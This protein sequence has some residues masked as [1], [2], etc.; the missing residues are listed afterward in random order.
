MATAEP[1]HDPAN[2]PRLWCVCEYYLPNFSGA[3]IQAHRI[4]ARLVERGF[5]VSVLAMA[6]QASLELAGQ[7]TR[8]D[9]VDVRYLPVLRQRSWGE[10]G[11]SS[12]FQERLRA[13]NRSLR[14]LSFQLRQAWFF[15]RHARPGDILQLYVVDDWTWLAVRVAR[16]KRMR[17][18]I[19]ISLVGAD[20]PASFRPT[21]WGISTAWKAA[22]FRQVDRVIGLSRALTNSC[23]QA[24][25][26]RE[27]VL[28]IPN[29]VDLDAFPRTTRDL[30]ET[31]C[32][33]LG[34]DPAA[35]R[36]AFVGSAIR[37][38]GID[39]AVA[40][41]RE[42]ARTRAEVELVVVGPDD[43]SDSTRH[44]ADRA[45]LVAQLRRSLEQDGISHRVHWAGQVD[46]SLAAHYLQ[47]SDI[48]FFPTRREGL[49]N[50][51]AEAMATGLPCV[52]SHLEGIT[53]DLIESA[54]E[55][56]LVAGESPGEYA[57]ALDRLCE[58]AA[59]RDRMGHAAR[60]RIERDFSLPSTVLQ[61]ERLYRQLLAASP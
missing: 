45:E 28:R 22:C 50:A 8:I 42:L 33:E 5:P 3:A 15:H 11:S 2:L 9:G 60:V 18:V 24:G 38:K 1:P 46:S 51:L 30:R 47:A 14:D 59:A 36:I 4:L 25:V 57:E 53:T 12:R 56:L 54:E 13:V 21:W 27:K 7:S 58:S 23:H 61:Y 52:A 31:R 17:T 55:G 35:T 40:A 41:F 37:R 10:S 16:W 20:D 43:F 26:P 19:Q 49:P 44:E 48:F 6:D 29:G 39:I 32:R 34:L